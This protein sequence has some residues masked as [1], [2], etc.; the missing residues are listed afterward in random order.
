M[1][2]CAKG[3]ENLVGGAKI[4]ARYF[5]DVNSIYLFFVGW[6]DLFLPLPYRGGRAGRGRIFLEQNGNAIGADFSTIRKGCQA[7]KLIF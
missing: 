7:K 1:G 3:A 2:W 4:I 5:F 6:Q